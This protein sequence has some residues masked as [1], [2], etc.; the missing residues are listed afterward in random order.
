MLAPLALT[1]ASF[2]LLLL[3]MS[4]LPPPL[5]LL[6]FAVVADDVVVAPLAAIHTD[7]DPD[8]VDGHVVPS[9][10]GTMRAPRSLQ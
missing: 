4:P 2:M 3:P 10:N 5:L 7:P 9:S 6:L 1:A 8:P